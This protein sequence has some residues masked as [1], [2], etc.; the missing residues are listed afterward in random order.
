MSTRYSTSPSLLLTAGSSGIRRYLHGLLCLCTAAALSLLYQRGYPLLTVLLL[1]P[2]GLILMHLGQDVTAGA[3]LRWAGGQ[4]SVQSGESIRRVR[5]LPSSCCLPWL[6]HVAWCE[7]LCSARG[8]LWLFC[9]CAPADELRRLRVR[10]R[11][12][13]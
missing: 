4:W 13:H 5:I 3:T 11:L 7:Q 12:E 8:A 10:L 6:I 1:L 2:S 9:D